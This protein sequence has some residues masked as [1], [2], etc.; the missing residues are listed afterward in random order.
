MSIDFRIIRFSGGGFRFLLFSLVG[1]ACLG[2]CLLLVF[3][4]ILS[5]KNL[6][7]QEIYRGVFLTVEEIPEEF[8]KGKVMIAEIHWDEPGV[9]LYFS[10]FRQ[11]DSQGRH[12]TLLPADYLRWE[13]DLDLMVN[14]TRYYPEEWW[15]SWP[16][17]SVSSLE[18]LVWD[19]TVSHIHP[20]SY[21]FG[22]DEDENFIYQN[23]KPPSAEFLVQLKWGMGVQSVSIHN[24]QIRE[25]ALDRNIVYDARTFLGV[26][27]VDK[28]LWL[29]VGETISEIGMNTIATKQ[30]VIVGGQLDTQ[31]A[32]NMI[33]GSDASGVR[34]LTGIRGR[35][36]LGGTMGVR[37]ERLPED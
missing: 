2:L 25:G 37:A 26:D 31:D 23:S 8:G 21:M 32:S 22:W 13:A 7:R 15:Q 12:F 27:P 5:P 4:V 6:P 28:V 33:I 9:E 19:G 34:A 17:R 14:T 11:N 30:G 10:P 3:F 18:T 20:L 35:R 36:M 16:L 29:I 1:L 24:G